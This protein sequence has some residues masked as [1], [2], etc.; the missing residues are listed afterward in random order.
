MLS[1]T[2]TSDTKN[3]PSAGLPNANHDYAAPEC[4][5]CL[6]ESTIDLSLVNLLSLTFEQSCLN[7]PD[8]AAR[9]AGIT[10]PGRRVN[11]MNFRRGGCE[12]GRSVPIDHTESNICSMQI[13]SSNSV[14]GRK[15]A[16]S[17]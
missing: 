1:R 8:T 6:R 16:S 3:S 13:G 10:R 17:R 11:K 4:A 14:K 7:Q 9:S 12:I 5:I 2:H 15:A